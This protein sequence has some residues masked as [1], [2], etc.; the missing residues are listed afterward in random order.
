MIEDLKQPVNTMLLGP[1]VEEFVSERSPV[2]WFSSFRAVV[3]P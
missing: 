1:D 2:A 3:L